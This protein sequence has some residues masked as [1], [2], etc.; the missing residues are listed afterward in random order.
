MGSSLDRVKPKTI[1]LVFTA[2]P[3]SVQ[4]QMYHM[5]VL[6]IQ[7]VSHD[8]T[9]Y[10]KCI[11][12]QYWLHKMYH[13]TVLITQNVSHDSTDY[14]K[15]ITWPYWLH[16]MYHMTVLI[17]QNISWCYFHIFL[18]TVKFVGVLTFLYIVQHFFKT[19]L[20]YK[21]INLIITG[22]S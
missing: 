21:F 3:V 9:D 8:S 22:S 7:N 2:T 13:M 1:K 17:T 16:K 19:I 5:T 4:L 18:G 12:W 6:I 11:I 10:T 15:C 14:T 20:Y